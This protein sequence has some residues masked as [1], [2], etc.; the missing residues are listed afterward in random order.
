VLSGPISPRREV[1][2]PGENGPGTS[3][4]SGLFPPKRDNFRSSEGIL[5]QARFSPKLNPKKKEI[6]FW[7]FYFD[8]L[9]LW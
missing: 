1:L 8:C 7:A 2:R 6:F 3:V 5:A 4:L 9:I